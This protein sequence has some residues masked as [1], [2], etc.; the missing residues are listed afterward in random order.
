[1]EPARRAT[2]PES[3]AD[4]QD[5]VDNATYSGTATRQ[6]VLFVLGP[7]R[8]GTSALTRVLSLCGATLPSGMLGADSGNPRGN[9]EPRKAISINEAIL[10]R[11]GSAWFDPSLRLQE[12]GALAEGERAACVAE[13][14]A[15]LKTLPAAP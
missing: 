4:I 9:W 3:I 5:V 14:S 7:Q 1:M 2:S 11:H 12:N 6:V 15:Y 13:L 8:S 10:Y